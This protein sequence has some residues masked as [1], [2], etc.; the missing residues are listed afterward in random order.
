M[1]IVNTISMF[2][3]FESSKE[4][5]QDFKFLERLTNNITVDN[6]ESVRR[7]LGDLFLNKSEQL[8]GDLIIHPEQGNTYE[9]LS[10]RLTKVDG[11]LYQSFE[12]SITSITKIAELFKDES[13]EKLNS[14]TEKF[15]KEHVDLHSFQTTA[16]DFCNL[17]LP[18]DL[19]KIN[20]I[21]NPDVRTLLLAKVINRDS[22]PLSQLN[23]DRKELMRLAPH[24]TFLDCTDAFTNWGVQ[25]LATM[26]V[27]RF[28]SKCINVKTLIIHSPWVTQLPL[29][30]H[31]TSL[32]CSD[33]T[34]LKDM[35]R[36]PKCEEFIA[37]NC[38]F[39]EIT[40][41]PSCR[42]F[43]CSGSSNF[44]MPA[45]LPRCQAFDCSNSYVKEIPLLPDCEL[46]NCAS[47]WTLVEIP[48]LP[49]CRELDCSSCFILRQLPPLPSCQIL[50]ASRCPLLNEGSIPPRLRLSEGP[51]E[52][53]VSMD[54]VNNNPFN[55]LLDLSTQLLQGRPIP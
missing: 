29:L 53:Q 24:L 54:G 40:E 23:L 27:N 19:A 49:K 5:S 15:S 44:K 39:K 33:C 43:N 7:Q 48:S 14:F 1:N 16:L 11:D 22:V 34:G 3:P 35:P 42:I 38:S 28:L 6:K 12:S 41:L 21:A 47:C 8:I 52:L 13:P 10:Q 31:C 2:N 37:K 18:E 45:E 50:E 51:I 36:L 9:L 55:I 26:Q 4:P 32:D 25:G 46:L 20:A 30:N 17:R